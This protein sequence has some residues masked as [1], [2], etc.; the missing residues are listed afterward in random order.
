M[1]E[2]SNYRYLYKPVAQN[3]QTT[4]SNELGGMGKET[5]VA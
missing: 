2:V 3:V 4:V 1:E 5:V